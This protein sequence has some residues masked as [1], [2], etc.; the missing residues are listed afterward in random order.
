M[1]NRV[2]YKNEVFEN[3]SILNNSFGII[4]FINCVLDNKICCL[5]LADYGDE[6]YYI[7]SANCDNQFNCDARI[8]HELMRA[9]YGEISIKDD[10]IYSDKSELTICGDTYCGEKYTQYR[11]R[12]G[13]SDPMQKY[14]D[15]GYLYSFEKV[16]NY[17]N[18]DSYNIVNSECVLNKDYLSRQESG[19][20]I[21]FV[22]GA[23]PDKT[24]KTYKQLGID[25]VMAANNHMKDFWSTGLRTTHRYFS[26]NG[27]K[28]LGIGNN[29]DEAEQPLLLKLK[30]KTIILFNCYGFFAQQ[31]YRI[32]NHYSLGTNTGTAFLGKNESNSLLTRILKYREKYPEAYIILSPHWS[33]DFNSNH[34]SLR[35]LATLAFESGVDLIIGH[36]PHISL[37]AEHQKGKLVVYSL[38]DFVFNTTGLDRIKGN[39][40]M[41]NLVAKIKFSENNVFLKLYPIYGHNMDTFFQPYPV[42]EHQMEHFTTDFLGINK[43]KQDKDELGYYLSIKIA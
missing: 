17:F 5:C 27:I 4:R 12:H 30:N 28:V 20:Y 26:E 43:F 39:Y 21:N 2:V 40:S 25:A 31:R 18:T 7:A 32:F 24:I 1:I 38:G 14:G 36:G 10:F 42:T 22:L 29:I 3:N 19:K 23:D 8:L 41:Y 11:I 6:T 13:I 35:A 37:G 16:K 33:N 9:K 15:D 34:R